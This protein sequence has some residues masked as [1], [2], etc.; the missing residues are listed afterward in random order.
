MGH[1][2]SLLGISRIFWPKLGQKCAIFEIFKP[3]KSN[4]L[5]AYGVCPCPKSFPNF[6]RV[7]NS[8]S[9][10]RI[11]C[12]FR[13]KLGQKRAIFGIFKPFISNQLY[14]Y[15]VC[16]CP[17]SF[18]NFFGVGQSSGFLG[19]SC[20]FWPKLGQKTCNF[21]NFQTLQIKQTMCLWCL[22]MPKKLH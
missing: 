4:Q 13:P 1:S 22:P 15:G 21:R 17:K 12:T 20:I 5:Y 8:S 19:I 18:P 2:S 7:G 6:F 16:T 10:P 11:S 3:I 9:F 14:A